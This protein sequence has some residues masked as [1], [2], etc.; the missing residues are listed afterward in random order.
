MRIEFTYFYRD[1]GNYKNFDSV[2]FANHNGYNAG[3]L[4]NSILGVLGPDQLIDTSRLEI[5]SLYFEDFPF[6]PDL[7]HYQHEFFEVAETHLPTNDTKCRDITSLLCALK[8]VSAKTSG[9]ILPLRP[10]MRPE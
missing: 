2:V 8:G 3:E 9:A 4:R 1:Y 7:D 10:M 5:P 6:D